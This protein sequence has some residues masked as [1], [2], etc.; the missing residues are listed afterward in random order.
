MKNLFDTNYNSALQTIQDLKAKFGTT[1]E[2]ISA[3]NGARMR[4]QNQFKTGLDIAKYTAAIMRKD[5]AEYD[6]DASNYTQSLGCWHGFVAQQKMIAVKKHHNTT[7]KRYL[8]LS[9]W[10][11]AALRSEFGPLPD[12]SMHEKTAVPALIAEIYD[13]LRQA[14]AI[15]LNDLFRRLELGED[16]QDQIDNFQT[17]I[18]PIIADIDAGFGNEE[19]TYLLAKKMIQA[20]ACAIQ[21]ENQVSDAKQCG[22]QDGKVTVPHEDFIA[23]LNAVRYA[24]LELGVDDGIIVARTDSEGAGLTQKLPVSKTKGDLA[25]KYLEFVDAN[26]VNIEDVTENEV[27]L[28]RNGQL[29]KPVRLANGLYKFKEGSNIDRVVLDCITSL[30]NGADLLWIETP[31]PNVKQ[32]AHMVNRVKDVVPNAK[33][34]YNNSPSFNWTLNFRNQVYE[35]MLAEGEN[36]TAYDRNNLMDAEYDNTEL[37]F[38]ADQKIKTFQMDAAREAGVFHH[39]ITLPTY[40]TTALHMNDLTKGYFGKDGMLAYVKDVQRQE[41]RK[42]VACV[43]HQRM[44]GSDLGDDHKTFF[45]GDNALKAGGAKNT[46]NQFETKKQVKKEENT[47]SVVA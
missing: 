10:M 27:L 14:D 25:S 20:G 26:P 23:K 36:M 8:Y 33:L 15:E 24:F 42:G 1:W 29:V 18:V 32:I 38:R 28:K 45:A 19:A 2:A 21:I 17:H 11:V 12:Q 22:H 39:L 47:I 31:T 16:V 35:E 4:F 43:K 34:V 40:H 9:G 37:S 46:S 44:A 5:M 30:Q 41:I 13:F 6:A 7:N 3:Q